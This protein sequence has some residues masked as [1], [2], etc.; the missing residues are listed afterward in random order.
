M[1]RELNKALGPSSS[2][3]SGENKKKKEEEGKKPES[4]PAGPVDQGIT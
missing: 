2:G 1:M 3:S 4:S